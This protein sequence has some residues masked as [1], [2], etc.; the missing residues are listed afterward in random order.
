MTL[1]YAFI[2]C[3]FHRDVI[4]IMCHADVATFIYH[5]CLSVSI[6]PLLVLCRNTFMIHHMFL[7]SGGRLIIL[8]S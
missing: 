7:S 2:H 5:F 3:L 6:C 1:H 4:F 8:V